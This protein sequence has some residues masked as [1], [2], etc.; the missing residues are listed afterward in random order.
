MCSNSNDIDV[1]RKA[2]KRKE[3]E[4]DNNTRGMVCWVKRN[5]KGTILYIHI[6]WGKTAAIR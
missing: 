2:L 5:W 1:I 4:L 3:R 6:I